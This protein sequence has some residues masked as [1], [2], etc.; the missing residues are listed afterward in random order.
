M[1]RGDVSSENKH[2]FFGYKKKE[3]GENTSLVLKKDL[4]NER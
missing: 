2:R 1:V 3:V 4:N